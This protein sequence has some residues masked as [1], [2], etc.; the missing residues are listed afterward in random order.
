MGTGLILQLGH[1]SEGYS[2][3]CYLSQFQELKA[4]QALAMMGECK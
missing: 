1:I 2:N 3:F 4:E